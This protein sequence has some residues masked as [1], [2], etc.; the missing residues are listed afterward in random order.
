MSRRYRFWTAEQKLEI[1]V[2][3]IIKVTKK[4]KVKFIN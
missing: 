2:K 3:D 1:I 4:D